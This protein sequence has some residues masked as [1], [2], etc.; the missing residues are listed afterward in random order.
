MIKIVL[1]EIQAGSAP[2]YPTNPAPFFLS[3]S[4]TTSS[5]SPKSY[6]KVSDSI[7]ASSPQSRSSAVQSTSPRP[8]FHPSLNQSLDS[9][10]PHNYI[11]HSSALHF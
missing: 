5:H 8:H 1:H 11:R 2:K 10:C 3:P 4:S 7:S 9:A 6:P